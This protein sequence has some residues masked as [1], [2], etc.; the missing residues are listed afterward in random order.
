MCR[1]NFHLTIASKLAQIIT[2]KWQITHLIL[3]SILFYFI[4]YS[5]LFYFII[6]FFCKTY[7]NNH[8][9]QI[10][11][12]IIYLFYIVESSKEWRLF[13]IETFC[14]IINNNY[15]LLSHLNNVFLM[16]PIKHKH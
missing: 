7:S 13:E 9:L 4:L 10:R 14:N 2:K 15:E 3:M 5:I 12:H 16:K 11:K 1:I 8:C 6:D